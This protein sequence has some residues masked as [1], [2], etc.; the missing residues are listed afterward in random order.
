MKNITLL[1]ASIAVLPA[2]GLAQNRPEPKTGQHH[3]GVS[4][5]V[6]LNAKAQFSATRATNPGPAVGGAAERAYDDGYN[7]VDATGNSPAAVGGPP[8]TSFFGYAND[9]QVV[10]AVGAGTLS[11]HAVQVNGGDY[12]RSFENR[13]QFPGVEFFYRYDWKSGTQWRS[14]WELGAS[15]NYFHW[16]QNGAPSAS[17]NLLTD[18]FQLGGVT[19][20]PGA[21]PYSGPATAL[22]GSPVIGSTPTRTEA[23]TAA[24]ITGER[25]L[26]LHALLLRVGP[27]LDWVPNE[28]WSVGVQ[29]GLALGVG[30]SQLS[31]AE[32]ITVADPNTPVI[33]QSGRSSDAHFWAGLFSSVRVNRRLNDNWDAHVAVRHLLTDALHHNGPT[34][35]G[36]IS[37]SD[38]LGVGAGISYR[39]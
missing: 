5:P 33:S 38:G 2:T 37:L 14:S 22:P 32:Q 24:A 12:T 7:R 15:Y 3:F 8:S 25:K 28:K 31:Y 36:K 11:L 6:L 21:A 23:T 30:L 27:T 16:S 10:N 1:L 29:G 20:F 13:P 26:Q 39:F 17:V 4:L 35:S 18:V 19:L 9:V 34:R